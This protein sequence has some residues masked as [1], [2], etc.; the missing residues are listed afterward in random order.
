MVQIIVALITLAGVISTTVAN[1][2]INS[3]TVKKADLLEEIERVKTD[4]TKEVN[5]LKLDNCKNYI[6]Q[7]LGKIDSGG[8]LSIVEKERYWENYDIYTSRGGNSYIHS[9]TEIKR[10]EGKL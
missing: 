4:L 8:E 3:R 5:G 9:E 1:V 7:A 6:V 2:I 10:K